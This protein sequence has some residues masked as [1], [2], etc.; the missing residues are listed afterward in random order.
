MSRQSLKNL[1]RLIQEAKEETPVADQ[2]INDLRMTVEKLNNMYNRP[3]SRK[4]KPSSMTCLRNMYYQIVGVEPETDRANACL[5]GIME[6]GSDRHERIQ[7]AVSKMFV[8]GVD[9]EYI[10][11]KTFIEQRKLD[12]LEVVSETAFETKVYHKG[13]NISFLCDGIIKYKSQY[14]I[15]EIKTETVYKWQARAGVAP[16]HIPQGVAY[17]VCFGIDQVM[18]VYENRDNTDK[19]AYVL[20]VTDEMKFDYIISKIEECDSYV[21]RLEV[22]PK[23]ENAGTKLCQYCNY[24][25]ECRKDGD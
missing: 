12:S 14:Y 11:V 17:S 16:E 10:D 18:F 20:E 8:F 15:L 1:H 19:K 7:D 23:P 5:V 2:F 24:K 25:T 13:L 4:Y 6:T 3:P 9:C 21:K 22:P